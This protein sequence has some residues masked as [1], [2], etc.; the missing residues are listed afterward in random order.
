MQFS[1]GGAAMPADRLK[2]NFVESR[3]V[4]IHVILMHSV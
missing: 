4:N 1:L 2:R 3:G